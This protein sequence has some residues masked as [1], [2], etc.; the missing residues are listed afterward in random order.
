MNIK[1]TSN[2]KYVRIYKYNDLGYIDIAPY[3]NS[4]TYEYVML[5]DKGKLTLQVESRLL[6]NSP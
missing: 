5:S 1:C 3:S 2:A 4:Q 6:I